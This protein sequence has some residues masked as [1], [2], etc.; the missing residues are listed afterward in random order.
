M[1]RQPSSVVTSFGSTVRTAF[2]HFAVQRLAVYATPLSHRDGRRET[3]TLPCLSLS[4]FRVS[5]K[6]GLCRNGSTQSVGAFSY[7]KESH[8]KR[9]RHKNTRSTIHP[10]TV[11]ER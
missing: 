3:G 11:E 6:I 8:K 7:A 2:S 4:P 9:D 10:R 5:V 1:A